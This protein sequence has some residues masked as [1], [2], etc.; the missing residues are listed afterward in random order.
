[1]RLWGAQP[2]IIVG[3][4]ILVTFFGLTIGLTPFT[5]EIFTDIAKIQYAIQGPLSG[6]AT[7]FSN[8]VF[9]MFAS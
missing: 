7:A 5:S 8:S 2:S 6:V 1:L 3:V 4:G 9:G